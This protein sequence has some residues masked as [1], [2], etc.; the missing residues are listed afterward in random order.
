MEAK[1]FSQKGRWPTKCTPFRYKDCIGSYT[2]L[3]ASSRQSFTVLKVFPNSGFL[4]N[5]F[6][7]TTIS[8][9]L[10]PTSLA[11]FRDSQSSSS[12]LFSPSWWWEHLTFVILRSSLLTFTGGKNWQCASRGEPSFRYNRGD[13][14][15][16]CHVFS[17]LLWFFLSAILNSGVVGI[18]DNQQ[19]SIRSSH[20]YW[21]E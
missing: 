17:L 3:T 14:S 9:W 20:L 13:M 5:Y 12:Q 7:W 15:Y 21:W 16:N 19:S 18:P 1:S 8:W 6:F 11:I 10:L 2:M 4:Q